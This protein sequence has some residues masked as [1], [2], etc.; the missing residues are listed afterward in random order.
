[1]QKFIF[2]GR[3]GNDPELRYSKDGLAIVQVSVAVA[4]RRKNNVDEYINEPLWIRTSFF[5]KRAE[6]VN[7]WFK[8]GGGIIVEGKLQKGK[9]Y[10]KKDGEW[11]Y[12]IDV[13]ADDCHFVSGQKQEKQEQTAD[14]GF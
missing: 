11:D 8:K 3:L 12:S 4:N 9:P 1:M 2:E 10:Q 6:F 7:Q 14:E 13:I 5:G